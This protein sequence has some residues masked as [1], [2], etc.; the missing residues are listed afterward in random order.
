FAAPAFAEDAATAAAAQPNC[1]PDQAAAGTCT[2]PT[3]ASG[4]PAEGPSIVVT[5]SRIRRPNETS[6]VPITSVAPQELTE[7][8]T[9]SL[10]DA[11]SE[12]PSM[13]TTFTQ[14]NSTAFIGTSGLNELDLRGQGRSR[15]LV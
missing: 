10:G 3:A 6:P 13:R 14:A 12:L 9:I 11:L 8:G 7:Q 4:A 5:G 15:T 1:T 2:L